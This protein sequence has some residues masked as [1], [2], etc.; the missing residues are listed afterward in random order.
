MKDSAY[1]NLPEYPEPYW[2]DHIELPEFP[3]LEQ[4]IETDAVIV[5]GGI[6][7]I[8]AAYLLSKEGLSVTLI[9]A[10]KLLNGTTGHTTAKVTAQ[11][12]LI[13]D[14]LINQFGEE[15]ARLYYEANDEALNLIRML[16]EE[17][18][19]ECGLKSEDAYVY[20]S[21]KEYAKK[22]EDEVKAYQKLGIPGGYAEDIP[23]PLTCE[24]A[25][26]M[27]GQAQFHPLLYLNGLI[28]S[29]L[30]AGGRIYEHTAAKKAEEDGTSPIVQTEQGHKIRANYLIT[31]SHFPFNDEMGMYFARMHPQRSYVLGVKTKEP[32]PG[33]MY[34]SAD[35]PSRSLRSVMT[36]EGELILVGGEGHKTGQGKPEIEHYEA[37]HTFAHET[38]QVEAIPYRWSAQ[39]L[40][41]VD[42]LP[43][44]G[45]ASK[46]HPHIYTATGFAKWGM[47]NGTIAAR[48]L[49]DMILK[50]ENRY[51]EL[52]DPSRLTPKGTLT[53]I[54]DN[55]NVAAEFI[56]GKIS[57]SASK[58]ED[59]SND[60]AA[61]IKING[62]KAGCYKDKDG[63]IHAVDSTCTHMGCE[64]EWNG[65]ERS[66]DCPC[67]GSRFSYSGKVLEGP[68]VDPLKKVEISGE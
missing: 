66:W 25:I 2:R 28:P 27:T 45:L 24:A 7:G 14:K 17:H 5:G 12:G 15:K 49:T 26:V 60:E 13:Y 21:T 4:D 23:F 44:I 39:D 34:I 58:L 18:S 51:T 30:E 9:E 47:T 68:A 6:T 56:K 42:N 57:S 64:L 8:T 31:A 52:F 46:N 67:H 32:Y 1:K 50:K 62:Q 48:I 53:A 54:K 11:H 33:G 41:T 61:L 16:T 3:S 43:Y 29:I 19:I 36:E 10:G 20:A 59:L 35:S 55:A 22:I 40:I 63:K 38:F 37:L 65:G